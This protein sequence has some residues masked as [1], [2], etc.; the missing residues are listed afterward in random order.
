MG[1]R[2]VGN[3]GLFDGH[4]RL[5]TVVVGKE[6]RVF[7]VEPFILRENSFRVL[8]K[9]SMKKKRVIFVDV[10]SILFEHMMWLMQT[11]HLMIKEIA[12]Y[13]LDFNKKEFLNNYR[14]I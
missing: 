8:M 12:N 9:I 14:K 4:E 3:D 13:T 5:V 2:L 7:M 11:T 10:D 6:R 1:Y